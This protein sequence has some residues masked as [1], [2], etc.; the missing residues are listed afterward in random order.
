[1]SMFKESISAYCFYLLLLTKSEIK[2]VDIQIGEILRKFLFTLW[3]IMY[4]QKVLKVA[5][6]IYHMKIYTT[7]KYKN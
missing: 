2:C 5:D 1:M 4:E 7:M 6:G 3:C